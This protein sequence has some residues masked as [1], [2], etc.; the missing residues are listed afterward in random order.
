M[1]MSE[2]LGVPLILFFVIVGRAKADLA[3]EDLRYLLESKTQK[4]SLS[5][6]ENPQQRVDEYQ[7]AIECY[8]SRGDLRI[9]Q[10]LLAIELQHWDRV[11]AL[12]AWLL[13]QK[14][15]KHLVAY[16]NQ[17][18]F[19]GFSDLTPAKEQNVIK[20]V[21][22]GYST[23]PLKRPNNRLVPV[24]FLGRD[25]QLQLN[26]NEVAKSAPFAGISFEGSYMVGSGR[27]NWVF[28]GTQFSQN[29]GND[30]LFAGVYQVN[31]FS[32]TSYILDMGVVVESGDVDYTLGMLGLE[33]QLQ[34]ALA[35]M[36]LG[37][38]DVSGRTDSRFVSLSWLKNSIEGQFFTTEI[39]KDWPAGERAGGAT[40]RL[41]ARYHF[42]EISSVAKGWSIGLSK[43]WDEEPYA[44]FWPNLKKDRLSMS[45]TYLKKLDKDLDLRLSAYKT[46]SDVPLFDES[47]VTLEWIKTFN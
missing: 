18:I 31:P 37:V 33:K 16:I 40:T 13:E 22:L 36:K 1:K 7:R 12:Y 24:E 27:F 2:A 19:G 4:E 15:P 29:L 28:E 9:A 5:Q 20:R 34:G 47:G 38:V 21:K 23:N 25:F 3:C 8:P 10:L 26:E 46:T 41:T 30:L 45:L 11:D 32:N 44:S 14:A 35:A 39:F 6:I 42:T 17:R 43:E